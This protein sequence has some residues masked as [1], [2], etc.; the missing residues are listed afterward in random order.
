L[1][2][3]LCIS[4]FCIPLLCGELYAQFSLEINNADTS[5]IHVFVPPGSIDRQ[6]LAIVEGFDTISVD[7]TDCTQGCTQII[8]NLVPSSVAYICLVRQTD[9]LSR[10][11]GISSS[12]SPGTMEVYF[13]TNQDSE[14]AEYSPA[15]GLGG[16]V[17]EASIIAR[18]DSAQKTIDV[19]LY[20]INRRAIVNALSAAYQ[21]G[22]RVRY[23]TGD[24]TNNTA[25]RNPTPPFPILEGNLGD[26]LM[27]HKFF[28][29]DA[30]SNTNAWVITG[31]T[32]MTTLQMYQD[33]NNTVM[34]N[35]Q[36]LA[37]VYEMEMDEMWGSKSI[38]PNSSL[39]R[40]G[41]SKSNN[42]PHKIFIGSVLVESYFS[43]S[44]N[45]SFQIT[46][47][48]NKAQQQV[49][50]ALLTFT[51]SGLATTMIN[52]KNRGVQVRGII[53]NIDD[54]G[55]EFNR[56]RSNGVF[57]LSHQP[58]AQLH[59]K[60]AVVDPM[61]DGGRSITITGSHNWTNNAEQN[62]DENTL[63]I[64]DQA[65]SQIFWSEFQARWCEVFTGDDCRLS[66]SI[67]AE[68]DNAE[69][70]TTWYDGSFVRI[71]GLSE[72]T[73][74]VQLYSF[75]GQ[76]IKSVRLGFDMDTHQQFSLFAPG[77]KPG[78]Y[79]LLISDNTGRQSSARFVVH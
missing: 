22:V 51:R 14:L 62:N 78:I 66:T 20:N 31:A 79:L 44:D 27:H 32:N 43:P 46:N 77:L 59:H 1:K 56:L 61:D 38:L 9:T 21:R 54:N 2:G 68:L 16:A 24:D 34:I 73:Q 25:L 10:I 63:I 6:L 37:R 76:H 40:F 4:I 29:I 39:S 70:I 36:S 47:A 12:V 53:E 13:T 64:H 33:H 35:D 67:R 72:R 28:V 50:F 52:L 17:L 42:T 49:S 19:A 3:L 8:Q 69:W 60:Y 45:T 11:W 57:V 71:K 65:L 18:I 7:L 55:S 26:P 23:V 74:I 75:G 30:G 58:E 15:T 41:S 5:S 48:L